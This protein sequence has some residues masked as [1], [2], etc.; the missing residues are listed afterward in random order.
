MTALRD[1]RDDGTADSRHEFA[2]N[3]EQNTRQ[4]AAEFAEESWKF[5]SKR[6]FFSS[7]ENA[8]REIRETTR[9]KLTPLFIITSFTDTFMHGAFL[10]VS[11][12]EMVQLGFLSP[13]FIT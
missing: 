8:A 1:G 13:R 11:A 3:A 7:C 6:G 4:S 5:L 10:S 9:Q 12:P 2:V